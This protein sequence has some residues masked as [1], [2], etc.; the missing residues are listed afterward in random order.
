MPVEAYLRR[1]RPIPKPF[2]RRAA[3]A[4]SVLVGPI[5][6][7]A[8][9]DFMKLLLQNGHSEPVEESGAMV[10]LKLGHYPSAAAL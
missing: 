6:R 10:P 1:G 8:Q 3:S 7:Q 9:D 4:G 2:A 5:L